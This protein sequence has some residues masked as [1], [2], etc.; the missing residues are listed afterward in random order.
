[1]TTKMHQAL[2]RT[3][4]IRPLNASEV[5]HRDGNGLNNAVSNLQWQNSEGNKCFE[6]NIGYIVN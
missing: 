6:L 1:M 2:A 4:L 3:C 5:H